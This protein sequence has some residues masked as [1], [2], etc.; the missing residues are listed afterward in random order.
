[1]AEPV[2]Q[3]ARG[4]GPLVATAVHAGHAVRDNVFAQLAL[5]DGERLREEDPFTDAWME[6][7]P[8]RVVALRS[9]FEVD[10]NRPREKAVYRFD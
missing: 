2:W 10:L 7:A 6:I 9:R 5:D 3:V 8:I 1:M 4:E